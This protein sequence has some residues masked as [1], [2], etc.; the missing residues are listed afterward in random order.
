M[1]YGT[2]ERIGPGLLGEPLNALTSTAFLVV[3]WAGWNLARRTGNRSAGIHGLLALSVAIGLGS[4][5]WHTLAT[6]WALILDV[7]PIS[8]F[9]VVFTWLYARS[10]LGMRAFLAVGAAVVF[11]STGYAVLEVASVI[12]VPLTYTPMLVV[13]FGLVV[14]GVVHARGRAPDRFSLLAAA[15]V[16]AL[17]LLFR[18]IDLA[19]CPAFPVGTHFLWHSFGAL[20]A[21]LAL[22]CLMLAPFGLDPERS[23]P[24]DRGRP[25]TDQDVKLRTSTEEPLNPSP[26]HY[27]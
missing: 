10:F 13:W 24:V 22:R 6:S 14:L 25:S 20:T 26:L 19:V 8:L 12:H 5:V 1:V 2:C 9:V 16:C 11:L 15:A 23:G 3:A 21:F 27:G 18:L 4:G 17:A 7:I